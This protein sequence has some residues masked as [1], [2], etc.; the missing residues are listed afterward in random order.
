MSDELVYSIWSSL[1]SG[2]ALILH[3]S[4]GV[5]HDVALGVDP[6]FSDPSVKPGKLVVH[7]PEILK[8]GESATLSYR[9][10]ELGEPQ[11]SSE[12]PTLN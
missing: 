10:P 2:F 8:S 5:E 7:L 11:L 4:E 9:K 1:P 12:V 6:V 3:K